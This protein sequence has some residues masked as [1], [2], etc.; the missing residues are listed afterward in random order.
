MALTYSRRAGNNKSTTQIARDDDIKIYYLDEP[1]NL[2]K[3]L[4]PDEGLDLVSDLVDESTKHLNLDPYTL[5]SKRLCNID[6]DIYHRSAPTNKLDRRVFNKTLETLDGMNY[7]IYRSDIGD[8]KLIPQNKPGQTTRVYC[9]GQSGSG[10]ST[11]CGL[12]ALEYQREHPVNKVF[13]I[14]IKDNDPAF[15]G[16]VSDLIRIPLDRKLLTTSNDIKPYSNSLV[17]FDDYE[18][19]DDKHIRGAILKLKN[20][21]FKLGRSLDISICS[22][23]HKSLGG[24]Q[25]ITDINESN[26]FVCS[27]RNNL[28]ECKKLLSTYRGYDKYQL[29]RIFDE[30]TR[31]QWWL[32]I[33]NPNILITKDFIKIID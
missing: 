26:V 16:V 27:P 25:S 11:M 8:I 6:Q 33:I 30:E 18:A 9:S 19:I 15:D 17:I 1:I 22:I 24:Q 12:Y 3:E 29:E 28:G 14:S 13:L 23:Q 32:A 7:K 4:N 31:S 20:K 2:L 10:K 5:D 21:I